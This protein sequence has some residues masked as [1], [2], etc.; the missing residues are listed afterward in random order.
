MFKWWGR[1]DVDFSEVLRIHYFDLKEEGNM[2]AS[3]IKRQTTDLGI[4]Y[5][6]FPHLCL[7]W[8]CTDAGDTEIDG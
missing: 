4:K 8:V 6:L 2:P 3:F 7:A 1:G 5:K